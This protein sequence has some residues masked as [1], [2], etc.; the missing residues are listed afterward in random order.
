MKQFKSVAPLLS[1]LICAHILIPHAGAQDIAGVK[2]GAGFV[3]SQ[4][5]SA[6]HGQLTRQATMFLY[7]QTTDLSVEVGVYK[8]NGSIEE[9]VGR[10]PVP[11]DADVSEI[12]EQYPGAGLGFFL[13]MFEN[14][15]G[16]ELDGEWLDQARST[17]TLWEDNRYTSYKV[18]QGEGALK[19]GDNL[20]P[21]ETVEIFSLECQS[22]FIDYGDL[23]IVKGTWVIVT[24]TRFTV[25]EGINGAD[26]SDFDWDDEETGE[27]GELGVPLFPGAKPVDP[28]AT[29]Y[30][31]F[32]GDRNYLAEG[33]PEKLKAFYL[34]LDGKY[35]TIDD[36]SPM[37]FEE[38]E[39]M[40]T[41]ILCLDHAG[42]TRAGD[43]VMAISLF[44]APPPI[45]SDL[46]GRTQGEWTVVC[47]NSWLEEDY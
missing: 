41:S 22:P 15:S 12:T 35:C 2:L 4:E 18:S 37:A 30:S 17:V 21:G 39:F 38:G 20:S 46:I 29:S 10:I 45:L 27:A 42:E 34:D 28:D 44:K 36:E 25:P 14:E 47:F 24:R 31:E 40:M 8:F 11:Q 26:D 13:A 1:F 5:R 7:A 19:G 16:M 23:Q 33:P 43:N 3:Y 32:F 6:S 9:A